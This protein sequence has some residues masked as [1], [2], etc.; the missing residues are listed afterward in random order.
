M[1]GFAVNQYFLMHKN[2]VCGS[3]LIDENSG[4]LRAYKDHHTGLSPFLGNAD[5]RRM[6]RWW[7][8]RAVPASRKMMHSILSD[9][10][11]FDSR[12]YLAKNL[13]LSLTDSYWIC[14]IDVDLDYDEIKLSGLV[15]YHD[16]KIPYHNHTS[17]DPNASLGGQMEKYWDVK[18]MPPRLI[19][20]SYK[21]FGQQAMNEGFATRIHE[22]Q[23]TM[24]PYASYDVD[25]TDDNGWYC[26]CLAFTND[27][28]E[29]VPAYEVLEGAKLQNDKSMYEN[30]I[31][32]CVDLGIEEDEIRKFMDYQT[33]TDFIISNTDE[34]LLNFGILRD[35]DSMKY[36]GPAPIYDSGNSM[37]YTDSLFRHTRVSLLE[38]KITSFYDTEEKMLKNIKNKKIVDFDAL[39]KAD[40]VIEYY[41]GHDFPEDRAT[42]IARNYELKVQM[43]YEFCNGKNISIYH[44]RNEG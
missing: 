37:F 10:E 8:G 28:V 1:G 24:I 6:S 25:R 4:G 9:A 39:P 15:S 12:E 27:N 7:D 22:M 43:A 5:T 11:C 41:V 2:Q 14:P 38:R 21:Y 16:E 19:K 42:I 33:L 26:S 30:Y 20:E 18:T 35:A 23:R 13:A 44:E 31:Q 34:H 40:E 32:I 29:L 17:Y 36:L 3:L